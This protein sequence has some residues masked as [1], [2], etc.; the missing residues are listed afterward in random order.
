[1]TA[2]PIPHHLRRMA[3]SGPAGFPALLEAV[4]LMDLPTSLSPRSLRVA[5]TDEEWGAVGLLMMACLFA[6]GIR[7]GVA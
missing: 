6:G 7:W 2:T 4:E 1:M 5:A 3:S